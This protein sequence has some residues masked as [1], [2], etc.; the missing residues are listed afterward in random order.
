LLYLDVGV[1]KADSKA[2]KNILKNIL[3]ALADSQGTSISN[4]T[5]YLENLIKTVLSFSRLFSNF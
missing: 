5:N 2:F 3:T 4:I 1:K